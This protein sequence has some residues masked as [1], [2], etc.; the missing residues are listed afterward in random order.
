MK[1]S[2]IKTEERGRIRARGQGDGERVM[3]TEDRPSWVAQN[4]YG[5]NPE[6][7]LSWAAFME[8]FRGESK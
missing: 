7:P 3:Y 5:L 2:T 1:Y 8:A 6:M 4:R